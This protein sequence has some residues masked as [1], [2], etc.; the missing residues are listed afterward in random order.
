MGFGG[1]INIAE[2]FSPIIEEAAK[3]YAQAIKDGNSVSIVGATKSTKMTS[4]FE[5]S[6]HIE[7]TFAPVVT[8]E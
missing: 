2:R 1:S 7:K 5:D 4:P 3:K 8:E 6:I